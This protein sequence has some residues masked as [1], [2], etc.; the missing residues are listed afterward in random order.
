MSESF[1]QKKSL[2]QHFLNSNFVPR[3]MCDAVRVRAEDTVVE[4][5]PGTGVLTKE[6]LARGATV[7]AIET[8]TRAVETLQQTFATAIATQQL[9]L[10][11]EDA[12]QLDLA[13]Y[14]LTPHQYKVVANIPY[15]L[16]GLL[17]RTFLDTAYQPSDLVFLVQKELAERIARDQK[18]SLLSLSVKV[19]GNVEYVGT[20]KRGHF[21]PPPQVDSAIVAVHDISH[22]YFV[23]LSKADFFAALKA[24]F[25]NKRKQLAPN[26]KNLFPP[27][28]TRQ[29][30]KN[31]GLP[32]TIR[33]EDIHLPDWHNLLTQLYSTK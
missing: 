33:A 19:F 26:L 9:Q 13:T 25:G 20:V 27:E 11:T 4:I 18:E 22:D 21:S 10:Y 31:I 32:E 17:F 16:S 2:G 15:Y 6:L 14:P 30:L 12:R 23:N 8:D 7:I 1:T 28:T 5:G 24:G 29:A 3:Q